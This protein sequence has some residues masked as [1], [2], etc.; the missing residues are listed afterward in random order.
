M[1]FETHRIPSRIIF[2]PTVASMRFPPHNI[3]THSAVYFMV[4]SEKLPVLVCS[5]RNARGRTCAWFNGVPCSRLVAQAIVA[6]RLP[7]GTSVTSSFPAAATL[8]EV[9]TWLQ[10]NEPSAG[11]RAQS[12]FFHSFFS[13]GA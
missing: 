5:Q 8:L 4:V 7:D 10:S 2:G 13:G 12:T 6:M 9:V 3:D 11:E 1:I